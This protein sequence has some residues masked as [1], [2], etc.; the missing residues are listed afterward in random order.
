MMKRAKSAPA[1]SNLHSAHM[2]IPTVLHEALTVLAELEGM[3]L[4]D[5]LAQLGREELKRRGVKFEI[6]G[7]QLS[8]ALE[9]RRKKRNVSL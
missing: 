9:E 6:S 3:T 5:L 8:S 2:K 7:D 1:R 4:S